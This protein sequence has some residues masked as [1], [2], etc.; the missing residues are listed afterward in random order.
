VEEDRVPTT[1][2][3]MAAHRARLTGRYAVVGC[4]LVAMSASAVMIAEY[5]LFNPEKEVRERT[6]RILLNEPVAQQVLGK[7]IRDVSYEHMG[8]RNMQAHHRFPFFGEH[9]VEMHYVLQGY[10]SRAQVHVQYMK[11]G[12]DWKLLY[13][14]LDSSRSGLVVLLDARQR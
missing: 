10:K 2:M 11:D 8:A 14:S 4:L 7:G 12:H 9:V 3:G 1:K 6:T 13:L 5:L